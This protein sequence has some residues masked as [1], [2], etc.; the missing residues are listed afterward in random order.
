MRQPLIPALALQDGLD[1]EMRRART[2][3][4]RHRDVVEIDRLG[5]ILPVL[6]LRQLVGLGIAVVPHDAVARGR[7]TRIETVRIVDRIG[8]DLLGNALG[9]RLVALQE[10]LALEHLE[11]IRRGGPEEI[12]LVVGLGLLD[13]FHA[14]IGVAV[15]DVEG[16]ARMSLLERLLERIGHVLGKRRDDGDL[17]ALGEGGAR[18]Q[19]RAEKSRDGGGMAK[20]RFPPNLGQAWVR[21]QA[22][23]LSQCKNRARPRLRRPCPETRRRRHREGNE[24]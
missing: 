23:G 13:E 24:R 15:L 18:K 17:A 1:G 14:R 22:A 16:D 20:H 6:G 5:E 4:R 3:R 9:L 12:D 11:S 2:R 21:P 8:A 19:G 7:E 10:L